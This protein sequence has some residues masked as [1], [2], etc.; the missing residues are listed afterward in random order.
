MEP[1][2]VISQNMG[3]GKN[4]SIPRAGMAGAENTAARI[5][6]TSTVGDSL[7]RTMRRVYNFLD[8]WKSSHSGTPL[9]LSVD[10]KTAKIVNSYFQDMSDSEFEQFTLPEGEVKEYWI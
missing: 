1:I 5:L 3:K 7:F 9:L 8:D 2:Y 4:G 10:Q 6:L